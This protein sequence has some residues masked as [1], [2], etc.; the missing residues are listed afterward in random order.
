MSD[1]PMS[2]RHATHNFCGVVVRCHVLD[3]GRRVVD[4]ESMMAVIAALDAGM[5]PT[6]A[7]YDKFM[8]WQR[9]LGT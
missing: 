5:R 4:E 3:D 6:Q 8:Q 2:V 9:G 7:D 1:I